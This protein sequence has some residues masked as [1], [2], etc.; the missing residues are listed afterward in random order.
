MTTTMKAGPD[1]QVGQKKMKVAVAGLGA[2]AVAVVR[3][4]ASAPYLELVAAADVRPQALTAFQGRFG[5]KAYDSVEALVKDPEVEVVWVSTPNQYH[6]EHTIL[7]A[8]HGKHVVV[9]KPMALNLDEA[10]RMVEAADKNAA[11]ASTLMILVLAIGGLAACGLAIGV[12]R[13]LIRNWQ[14]HGVEDSDSHVAGHL[15]KV[16]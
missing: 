4:M 1:I 8:N 2:G 3:S 6:C 12:N 16:A 14:R 9:E 11:F 7:A 15:L 10:K 5:G 13:L